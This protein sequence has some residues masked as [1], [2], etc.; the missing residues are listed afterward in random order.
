MGTAA[1]NGICSVRGDEMSDN[2][3][4]IAAIAG[5]TI[6]AVIGP[7]DSFLAAMII[8]MVFDYLT[9]L[10]ASWKERTLSSR[11]GMIGL[12]RKGGM[13]VV[14][15]VGHTIDVYVLKGTAAFRTMVIFFFLS[16]EGLSILE[17]CGRIGIPIPGKLKD[18]IEALK[19]DS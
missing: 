19:E 15:S 16:N 13:L 12:I 14:I 9:G 4:A 7:F 3:K 11:K 1:I 5:F 17:N 10:A 18:A 2:I 6:G 8:F